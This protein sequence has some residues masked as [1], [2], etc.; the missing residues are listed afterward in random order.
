MKSGDVSKDELVIGADMPLNSSRYPIKALL[1]TFRDAARQ[2]DDVQFVLAGRRDNG[3][4]FSIWNL[5]EQN[6]LTERVTFLPYYERCERFP[7]KKLDCWKWVPRD[8]AAEELSAQ[9]LLSSAK[10]FAPSAKKR[11][12]FVTCF[13][14]ERHE[15]NSRLMRHW[16]DHLHQA[17]YEIHVLYY[18]TDL[19][20]VTEDMKKRARGAYELW[21][22]APVETAL[23][24]VNKNGLNVHVDDWCGPEVIEA[25]S[26]LVS[27]FEYDVAVVNYAFMTAVFDFLADYTQK[28]L[29]SHDSFV[30]R[31]RRLQQQGYSVA[32]WV[33][34]DRH[35][36]REA[37]ARSDIVVALQENEGRIFAETCGDDS[38]VRVVS[39]VFH[40][41]AA[42]PA[43]N[44]N[45]KL[46]IGYIG[47]GNWENEQNLARYLRAWLAIPDLAK[48]SEIVVGGGVCAKFAERVE[49]GPRLVAE[50][51]PTMLGKVDDIVDFYNRCDIVVN[52]ERGGTGI[53]VKALEAMAA[54]M[55]VIS[56]ADG[57]RGIGSESRFH[58][59]ADCVELAAL[60]NEIAAAPYVLQALRDDTTEYYQ[61]YVRINRQAM[62]AFLSKT[63]NSGPLVSVIIPFYNVDSYIDECLISVREQDY[64]NIEIILVDD[65]S[66]DGSRAIVERHAAQ[67]PR[68]MLVTH[69]KNQGLGPARNTGVRHASGEYLLFLD[70]DDFFTSPSAIR[71]L[72]EPAAQHGY[73]VVAGACVNLFDDG[74]ITDRDLADA[75]GSHN[76]EGGVVRGLEAF[77]A[78]TR[79]SNQYYLP[80]RAWGSLI[81]RK[82]YDELALDFPSGEH[83][84]M[85]HTP[86]LYAL[87]NGVWFEPTV[88][89]TY[90]NRSGSISQSSWGVDR[91][92]RYRA[93]WRHVKTCARRF[94]LDE[95]LSANALQH[96]G[97]VLW[98][99]ETSGMQPEA[100]GEAIALLVDLLNDVTDVRHFGNVFGL[101]TEVRKFLGAVNEHCGDFKRVL[102]ALPRDCVLDYYYDRLWLRRCQTVEVEERMDV[103]GLRP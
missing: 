43:P 7:K 13:H 28:I 36:E 24:G 69:E 12:L 51:R 103:R 62:A 90:R 11:A 66:P 87:A 19:E 60:T 80:P 49:D 82:F 26:D 71:S 18:A 81:R 53:A 42:T 20:H 56:T 2:R 44:P 47:S 50:V 68:V 37:F 79:I 5:L 22:E 83:E 98:R 4:S 59:A 99:L 61:H 32:A 38:K 102:G 93:L 27:R 77:F 8:I 41:S 46:R 9:R 55:P 92:R 25:V 72:L 57:A 94:G 63:V 34:L 73:D 15:G 84:D 1:E 100:R 89:V 29:L 6:D 76:A 52:P 16:L 65:A 96:A 54:G 97:H 30:D 23:V 10:A 40:V 48:N 95:G 88:I 78:G 85:G 31:N 39:P 58:A 101:I 33:S 3:D 64:L 21:R 67:D 14:P 70:S 74:R 45:G 91:L 17:G 75:K 35:G 86:F